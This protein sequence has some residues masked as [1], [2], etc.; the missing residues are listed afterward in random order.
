MSYRNIQLDQIGVIK[1]QEL[2]KLPL[3]YI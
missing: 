3:T 1:F 2:M